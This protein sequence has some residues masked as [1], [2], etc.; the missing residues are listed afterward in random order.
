MAKKITPISFQICQVHIQRTIQTKLTKKP[1]SLA[2]QEL[3]ELSRKLTL[4]S[5]ESFIKELDLWQE[6]HREFLSEKSID[7][8]GRLRYI[9]R[10]LRSAHYTL[11]RN[12]T[13]LFTYESVKNLPK[14]NNGLEGKFAHL[15][16]KLRVHSG[17][18]LENKMSLFL[19][20]LGLKIMKDKTK[21]EHFQHLFFT[22]IP[23][24]FHFWHA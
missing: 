18:K 5:K 24:F 19:I 9:H 13:Y 10:M 3:L 17:L 20:I 8:S 11:K 23:N 2:G 21:N 14:T 4:L 22:I 15:K 16:T 7:D 12:L 6:K 1:K